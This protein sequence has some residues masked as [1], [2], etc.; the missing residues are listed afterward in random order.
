MAQTVIMDKLLD[1]LYLDANSSAY[2]AGINTLYRVAKARDP[3]VT[4]A[5]VRKYLEA[6]NVYSLHKPLRKRFPRNKVT[7][8]GLHT[9]WMADLMDVQGLKRYNKGHAYILVIVDCFSRLCMTA[10]LKSKR[11]SDVAAR[12]KQILAQVQDKP[13][14]LYVDR[15]KEWSGQFMQCLL[16]H[17]I[18]RVYATSQDVKAM[19]SERMIKTVK[20]RLYKH[21]THTNSFQFLSVLPKITHAI[22]NTVCRVTG[23]KP[24]DITHANES[25]VRAKLEGKRPMKP[26]Q[27]YKVG[28]FV[29][30]SKDKSIFGKSY[31]P[32]Y[33]TEVFRIKHFLK[34]RHPATYQL[35]A[36]DGEDIGG[37]YY[38]PE[39]S[40][41]GASVLADQ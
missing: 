38:E 28:D 30:I 14:F 24:V 37:I 29:R 1:S 33:T 4:Q 22:N 34:H 21:F 18:E 27:R 40:A 15:G 17:G 10:A 8:S 12:F 35:E 31:V 36:L 26:V 16:D 13:W 2:F 3:S 25:L 5:K 19:T 7:A 41:V 23:Y 39:L 20:G 6:Q 9:N 32:N 11:A